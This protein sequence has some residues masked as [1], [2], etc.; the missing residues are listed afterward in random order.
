MAETKKKILWIDDEIELLQPHMLFLKDRGYDITPASNAEDGISLIKSEKFDLILLDEMLHGM[1][2]LTALGGIKE[3]NPSLPVIM[4]TKSEKESL[5][6][7]A[8]GSRI[9]DYLTKPVNPSQILSALKKILDSQKFEREKLSRDYVR[10]FQSLAS[11]LMSPLHAND[12]I[13]VYMRIN[14]WELDIDGHHGLGLRQMLFSQKRECNVA[15]ARFIEDH[16]ADWINSS[17]RPTLSMDIFGKYVV[18]LLEKGEKVVFIIV[19]N[20]RADQWLSME[21]MLYP[22]Y[23]INKDYYF[24]I[25]PTATP[26]SR[27]AIF[28]GL[29]PLELSEK[30]PALWEEGQKSETSRNKNEHKFLEYQL[31]HFGLNDLKMKY[32]KIIEPQ[33]AKNVYNNISSYSNAPLLAIVFNFIDFLAHSRSDSEV[34]KEIAPDEA[35]FR[36]L[37]R[38]WFDHSYFFKTLSRLAKLGNTVIISS[39][40]GSVRSLRGAKVIGDRDTST[41]LRYKFGKSLKCDSKYAINVKDPGEFKLPVVGINTNYL[42]AKEDYYFVYP[43]DYHHYLNYYRD[44]FQHGGAA[45]E[46]M[47]L[48]VIKLEPK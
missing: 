43:T 2:G 38:S 6:E 15:F 44:T 34:L 48:P 1:D 19:D 5:M 28:S 29:T 47:I 24:S 37:T 18:P 33:E 32:V 27:N 25:L 30:F 20:L 14:E 31:H 45:M 22:Y 11:R 9:D 23:R 12:W 40:H 21:P 10:D 13:D 41:N 26:Y 8:I 4:I 39:D 42:I 17:T 7:E 3:I 16:Y 36:S 46:E 35:A